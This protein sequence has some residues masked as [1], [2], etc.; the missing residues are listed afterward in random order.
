VAEDTLVD[1]EFGTLLQNF[2][3]PLGPGQSVSNVDAG[4][5]ASATITSTTVNTATWT[6]W[7]AAGGSAS[8]ISVATVT[9]QS[10]TG[11]LLTSL[12]EATPLS[13]TPIWLAA[14][15]IVMLVGASLAWRRKTIR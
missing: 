9:V 12:G 1:S 15:V 10:P 14:I 3:Y 6:A 2:P 8:D 7:D 4:L 5:I 13:L 11:V